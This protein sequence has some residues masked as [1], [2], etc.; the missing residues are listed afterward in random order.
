MKLS[1]L[2]SLAILLAIN[3]LT[4]GQENTLIIYSSISEPQYIDIE[5]SG[6]S[7]GDIY[8]RHGEVRLTP[9]GADV[10]EYYTT[11]TLIYLDTSVQKSARSFVA[12][13][14]LPEGSIYKMDLVQL[15][16]GRPVEAGHV[17]SGAIV[18]GTG[19]YAGIRGTYTIEILPSGKM[20]KTTHIYWTG[21]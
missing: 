9:D 18:G 20:S 1:Q 10:G 17:H 2:L 3:N 5:P 8:V 19:T 14:I 12:E 4:F 11:A 16:H 7:A 15:D 21:Q 6:P 13:T